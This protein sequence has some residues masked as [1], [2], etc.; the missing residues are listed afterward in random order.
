MSVKSGLC[1]AFMLSVCVGE[2]WEEREYLPLVLGF[3]L[4][5]LKLRPPVGQFVI[6]R[7]VLL[8]DKCWE[9]PHHK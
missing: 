1:T 7:Q 9:E 4:R 5:D 8:E 2:K 6:L 3:F